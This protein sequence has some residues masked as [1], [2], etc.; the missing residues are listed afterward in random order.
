MRHQRAF[1]TEGR[2]IEKTCPDC[3]PVNVKRYVVKNYT[4]YTLGG[5][6]V[7]CGFVLSIRNFNEEYACWALR[8]KAWKERYSP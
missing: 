3:K 5:K 2:M 4:L 1:T 7:D 8:A 6:K